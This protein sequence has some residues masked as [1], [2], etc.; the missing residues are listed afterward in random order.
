MNIRFCTRPALALFCALLFSAACLAA[1]PDFLERQNLEPELSLAKEAIGK[2]DWKTA[3]PHLDKLLKANPDNAD[4]LT[5][6][7]F[8]AR[9][10]GDLDGAFTNYKKAL[11]LEPGNLKALEYLGE[12]YLQAGQPK[13]ARIQLDLLEKFC[14]KQCEEWKD[15]DQE[16]RDFKEKHPAK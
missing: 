6:S 16:I 14:S 5:L 8:V 3:K 4:V 7:A 2:R 10:S 1:T 9:K 13:S 12:A 15:L 11:K